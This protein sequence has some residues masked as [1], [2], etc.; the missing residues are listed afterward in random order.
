MARHRH[1]DFMQNHRFWLMDVVPSATFPFL[2]L[3][4]PL[5]GFQSITTPEYTAEVDEIKQLNSMY[6]RSAYSGGSVAPITLTRGVLG[7]DDT[8]WQWMLR[9][10]R[11]FDTTNRHLLLLHF[12]SIGTTND[13]IGVGAWEAA[14]FL[15]GKA[16]LLWDCLDEDTEILTGNGWAGCDDV[17]IGDLVYSMDTKTEKLELVPVEDYVKRRRAL[18]DDI[19]SIDGRRFN[20]RVTG[21]HGLFLKHVNGGGLKR[22][23]ASDVVSLGGEHL[24]PVSG[25][26]SNDFSGVNLTDDELRFFAWFA[27]DGHM[28]DGQRLM[29][30]QSKDYHNDIRSLLGRIGLHF[31]EKIVDRVSGYDNARPMH[32]FGIPKG[33]GPKKLSGWYQYKDFLDK[34]ISKSLL[35]MTREQFLVFWKELVRGNGTFLNDEDGDKW[36]DNSQLWSS[37]KQQADTL[38]WMATVRGVA[39]S[40]HVRDTDNGVTMYCLTARD[41]E[42]MIVRPKRMTQ[43]KNPLVIES[44]YRDEKVWCVSNKN[45]TIITRR[46]GKVSIIGNCIP[47]R[48]KAGTDFEAQGGQVSIAELEIQP[49]AVTEMTLQSPL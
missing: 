22:Y 35:N 20:F 2:V 29:I 47:T 46:K 17:K 4:A 5:L 36:L 6:K 45:Q 21:K 37:S 44:I 7:Y 25:N 3:G 16:W 43:R 31:T 11:G 18:N 19:V 1:L 27:T 23:E 15:P 9:A 32:E 48:Y 38:L 8:M 42:W 41:K 49:W 12:T 40:C 33:T 10:I 34:G 13:D 26:M 24:M 39:M 14:A 30:T 28:K